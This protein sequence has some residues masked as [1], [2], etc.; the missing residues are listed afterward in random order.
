MIRRPP[1][2]TPTDTLFPYPTLFRSLRP[3]GLQRGAGVA[4]G[5]GGVDD[6]VDQDAEAARDV[7]D[8]VH[9]FRFAGALAALVD[10]RQRGVV[11]PFRERAGAHD[12]AD[13]EIGRAH[14]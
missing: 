6:I 8:D 5:A 1:R 3:R 7:A 4:E 2:S 12:A 9:H 14:V 13:V 10:D 11:E